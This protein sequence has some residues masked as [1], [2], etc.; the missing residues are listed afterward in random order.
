[1]DTR[2]LA[3]GTKAYAGRGG[4]LVVLGRSYGA[5]AQTG[6]RVKGTRVPP[7]R[8]LPHRGLPPSWRRILDRTASFLAA[9]AVA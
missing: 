6:F 8:I 7:R 5:F 4:I 9:K 2:A 3:D 1:M